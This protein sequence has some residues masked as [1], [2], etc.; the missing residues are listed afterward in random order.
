MSRTPS[1]SVSVAICAS[2]ARIT[3]SAFEPMRITT[4][5]PTVSPVPL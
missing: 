3:S 2:V 4:M 5:P 1:G